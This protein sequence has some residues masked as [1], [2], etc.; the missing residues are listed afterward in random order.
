[1]ASNIMTKNAVVRVKI[2]N[3]FCRSFSGGAEIQRVWD[4]DLLGFAI[5]VRGHDN[6]AKWSW[7]YVYRHKKTGKQIAIRLGA[8]LQ[9]TP[10]EARRAAK[11]AANKANTSDDVWDLRLSTQ[12]AIAAERKRPTMDRLWEEYFRAE[13]RHKRSKRRIED[14]W[15]GYLQPAFGRMKVQNVGPQDVEKFKALEVDKPYNANRALAVLSRMFTV[16]VRWGYR[17]GCAPEHPVKGVERYPEPPRE[18]YFNEAEIGRILAA[19]DS[20]R[21]KAGALALLMLIETGARSAEVRR[22]HWDQFDFEGDRPIWTV[23]SSNTKTAR[24]IAR[25]L[26]PDLAAR[27]VKW[28]PISLGLCADTAESPWVFP[29]ANDSSKPMLTLAKAWTYVKE[30]AE[31]KKSDRIHD[32][33]HTVATML[34][35]RGVPLASVGDYLG[36]ATP[37]TTRRY[38]HAMIERQGELTTLMRGVLDNAR[39]TTSG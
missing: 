2:N 36:H 11:D 33:R 5:R 20:L 19:I 37:I 8:Y 28:R 32:L 4:S 29:N 3:A 10:D 31:L 35:R 25:V 24:P 34:L 23:E 21:S 15:T 18:R 27:L 7:M 6:P 22:A 9:K 30:R 1:M 16:A 12:L 17:A 26:S 14:L 38:A 39:R 13:G